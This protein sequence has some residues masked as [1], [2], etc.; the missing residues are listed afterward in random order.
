MQVAQAERRLKAVAKEQA[1]RI[2]AGWKIHASEA[3]VDETRGAGVEVDGKRMGLR[4]RFD[5]IDHHAESGRWAI[6]DYKTHGHRPEKK[7]LKKTDEGYQWIDLQLPLY[8]M[9][10]PFLGID[11]QPA[12]VQLGYFNISEK[13]EET[14]I[15]IAEFSDEQMQQAEE[16]IHDCI[17]GIWAGDFEPTSDRVQFDDYGM[18]L[19]TGVASRLLDQTESLLGRG[20][21]GVS[22]TDSP[23]TR[24][25]SASWQKRPSD[26]VQSDPA[27]RV[28]LMTDEV[29]SLVRYVDVPQQSGNHG[30]ST[31]DG[32]LRPTL[33]RASAGT[34]KTYRLTARLLRILL[35]GAPPE[36]ILA[37]TFTRKAAG[38]ILDRVLLDA[39]SCGR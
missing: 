18:I 39:G 2:A 23:A 7:H 31:A 4:G 5:R 19:Q 27:S 15:N 14:R 37:T 36:S 24:I 29:A 16:L 30:L 6:L 26:V 28:E 1:A 21:G 32:L 10:I 17:R 3:S 11:A 35:Q 20:G 25:D 34:G 38:E 8:R 22:K 33:V 9:M 12:D 13:D